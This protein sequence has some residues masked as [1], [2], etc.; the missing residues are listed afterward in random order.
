MYIYRD[1]NI[2]NDSYRNNSIRIQSIFVSD[3]YIADYNLRCREP[4]F[5]QLFL[6]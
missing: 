5:I 4:K 6:N 3:I 2:Y 1:N